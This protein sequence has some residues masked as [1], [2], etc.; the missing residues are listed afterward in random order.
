MHARTRSSLLVGLSAALLLG[1]CTIAPYPAYYGGAVV[2]G[3]PPPPAR[4]EVIGVAPWP[5][6]VWISGRWIW[7]DRWIWRSGHWAKPPHPAA[8][9]EAGRW[10]PH[11]QGRWEWRP[12]RWH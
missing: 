4:V 7:S 9:W 8:H 12:G 6:A 10:R 5:G 3:G 11:G 1:G 2:V